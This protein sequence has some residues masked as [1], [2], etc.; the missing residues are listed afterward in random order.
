MVDRFED[1]NLDRALKI[2]VMATNTSG[3]SR[4]KEKCELQV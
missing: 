3:I 4:K 1:F 2:G